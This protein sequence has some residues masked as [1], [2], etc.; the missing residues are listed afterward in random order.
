MNEVLVE[1]GRAQ[2]LM[3]WGLVFIV[4]LTFIG[5]V[6]S[7]YAAFLLRGKDDQILREISESRERVAE[8]LREMREDSKR[9]QFYLFSKLGPADL[10]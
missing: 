8:I 2:Q 5:L 3:T 6:W 9:M 10:E 4:F 1:I 7:V